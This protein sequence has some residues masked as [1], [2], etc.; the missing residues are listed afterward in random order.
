M[1]TRSP[2]G[3]VTVSSCYANRIEDFQAQGF[4]T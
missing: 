3:T 2:F 1:V 4:E